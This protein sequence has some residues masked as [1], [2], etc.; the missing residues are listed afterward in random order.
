[1]SS[2][3][4]IEINTYRTDISNWGEENN[5]KL[6]GN[7][8]Y[9]NSYSFEQILSIAV[10]YKA[11]IIIKTKYMSEKKPGAWYI[12]G[13]KERNISYQDVKLKCEENH[14]NKKWSSRYCYLINYNSS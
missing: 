6:R 14:E 4:V 11:P 7:Q 5:L 13:T 3:E 8:R 12:K 9:D 10:K 1:M 2:N